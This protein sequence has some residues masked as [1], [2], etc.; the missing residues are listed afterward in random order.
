MDI[1]SF[2]GGGGGA[3]KSGATPAKPGGGKKPAA[4]KT[5]AFKSASKVGSSSK[6][7]N[8]KAKT[9]PAKKKEEKVVVKP[10]AKKVVKEEPES[11]ESTA[12]KDVE[13]VPPESDEEDEDD[14]PVRKAAA[15]QKRRASASR[16][17]VI[18]LSSD[19]EDDFEPPAKKKAAKPDSE[20][21]ASV[22]SE[23]EEEEDD[24]DVDYVDESP[25]TKGKK[26]ASPKGKKSVTSPISAAKK[27]ASPAETKA[28]PASAAKKTKIATTPDSFFG[29]SG[30]TAV[31]TEAKPEPVVKSESVSAD[32]VM[33]EDDE[34]N[35]GNVDVKIEVDVKVEED[36]GSDSDVCVVESPSS[37]KV[38]REPAEVKRTAAATPARQMSASVVG[39]AGSSSTGG[40]DAPKK[41]WNPAWQG[42]RA[43]A[44][45]PGS[46]TIPKAADNCLENMKFVTTGILE[47]M[48]R[49][50]IEDLILGYGGKVAKAV[51]GKTNY[52]IAG[53]LLDDGRPANESKKYQDALNK[54]VKILSEDD[55]LA[56]LAS[57]AIEDEPEPEPTP[58]V[59]A[60][61]EAAVAKS[62]P[63]AGKPK[64]ANPYSGYAK[65][66]NP[67]AKPAAKT[68]PA[69][70]SSK[71]TSTVSKGK[72]K[73]SA[74][75]DSKGELWADKYKPKDMSDII[76]NPGEIKKLVEWLKTWEKYHLRGVEFPTKGKDNPGAKAA[77]ISGPP[78]IG[79]TSSA[80]VVANALG[81]SVTEFNASDTRNKAAMDTEL[82]AALGSNVLNWSALS[83]PLVRQKRVVI[84]DEVDGM[85]GGDRGGMAE[86]MKLIKKS[87]VPIICICNDRQSTKVRSLAN[88]CY[89]LRF[90]RPI[91]TVIAKR[92][93]AI[94]KSEGLDIDDN[95]AEMLSES[96]GNDIRQV[97]HA[98]QMWNR[99]S[100]KVTYS[101]MKEGLH[102]ISKDKGQ[103]VNSFDATKMILGDPKKVPLWERFE[104]FFV[105]YQLIPLLVQQNWIDSI[106]RS[107][108]STMMARFDQAAAAVSDMDLISGMVRGDTNHWELLPTQAA[109][110]CRVGQSVQGW[111]AMP[112]FPMWLGQNS[113][114]GKRRRLISELGMHMNARVTGDFNA[115]RL[116]YVPALQAAL[117]AP[118]REEGAEG[119]AKTSAML[120]EYGL[121]RDDLFDVLGEFKFKE[122]PDLIGKLDAKAKA[123]L[124]REYNSSVHRSQA[125]V[126]EMAL[127]KKAAKKK[128]ISKN[129]DF[130]EAGDIMDEDEKAALAVSDKEDSDEEDMSAFIKKAAKGKGK[131][132]AS[133][134]T[135]KKAPA[136]PKAAPNAKPKKK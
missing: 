59:V 120:D 28:A 18:T 37:P 78:G 96:V 114:Q 20:D 50:E 64:I 116:S 100:D 11:Q 26:G 105:D 13:T 85:G 6:K 117:T 66:S 127:P 91:K 51:S 49:E 109:F 43:E 75:A 129:I 27:R 15:G 17:K 112:A 95:A 104:A 16:S 71:S 128:R 45:N 33:G 69:G 8:G 12:S 35:Q 124:T 2:F 101:Q 134:A 103:R 136:K 97:L 102:S 106:L 44:L 108:K 4:G 84:M 19:E 3:S 86:L 32:V 10:V 118:M 38:K 88:H 111:L 39:T 130:E 40:G 123:A 22:A 125:L 126:E 82:Q 30:S 57:H 92:M 79:K 47:S 36:A 5:P 31:K 99:K 113:A 121:S 76:G 7:D 110:T 29:G 53:T 72:G 135:T 122:R 14:M 90:K 55:F 63:A 34:V 133:A 54:N 81:Y 9:P 56:L 25:S 42:A 24:N 70:A 131:A 48:G 132:K 83:G 87:K 46:K 21:E 74:R 23:E 73:A 119:A 68:P 67:Y 65:P 107:E 77:L 89:D 62:E 80:H 93:K 94:A 1:R 41:K 61:T 58:A 60:K 98:L 52:L 115:L